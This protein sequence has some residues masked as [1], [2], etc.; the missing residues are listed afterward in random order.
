MVLRIPSDALESTLRCRK[1]KAFL[2]VLLQKGVLHHGPLLMG[3]NVTVA[4]PWEAQNIAPLDMIVQIE[5]PEERR[6]RLRLQ[7]G[8]MW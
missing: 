8:D 6:D 4:T 5:H 2:K 7:G 1:L 3:K